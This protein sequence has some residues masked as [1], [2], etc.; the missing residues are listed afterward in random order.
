MAFELQDDTTR[1]RE[2]EHAW[3]H[4]HALAHAAFFVLY[5][6]GLARSLWRQLPNHIIMWQTTFLW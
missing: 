6:W 3:A 4:T 2:Q 5:H 1:A